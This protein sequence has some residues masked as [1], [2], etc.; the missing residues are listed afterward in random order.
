MHHSADFL[1]TVA[2]HCPVPLWAQ[3]PVAFGRATSPDD[4]DTCS[5]RRCV[6]AGMLS[7]YSPAAGLIPTITAC[8]GDA[9]TVSPNSLG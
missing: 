2:V 6:P 1:T 8:K 7:S 4:G 9:Y 3:Q 5:S